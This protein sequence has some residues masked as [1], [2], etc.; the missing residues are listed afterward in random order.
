MISKHALLPV[1]HLCTIVEFSAD[2]VRLVR[3][4][5]GHICV[6]K[7]D[8]NPLHE[9][10]VTDTAGGSLRSHLIVHMSDITAGFDQYI[11]IWPQVLA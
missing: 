6:H 4:K 1:T 7:I 10:E 3:A 11:V 8:A 9:Q 5:S 2:A